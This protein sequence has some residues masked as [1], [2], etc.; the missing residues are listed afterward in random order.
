MS[1]AP[2]KP[3]DVAAPVTRRLG[4]VAGARPGPLLLVVAGI[5]GNE[6]AGV[7]ALQRVL[8][9]LA[10]LA[11]RMTG[12]VVALAGNLRALAANQRFLHDDL[13]RRW[14][15]DEADRVRSGTPGPAAAPEDHERAELL[16]ELDA[17]IACARGPVYFL[18]LHTTSAEGIPFAMVS[19][20]ARLAD[21]ALQFPLPVIVGML[22]Q[23]HGV[24]LE[25]MRERGCACLGVEGGQHGS[26]RSMAHHQAVAWIAAMAAGLVAGEQLPALP[27]ALKLLDE[28]RHGLPHVIEVEHRHA[29]APGDQFA[30]EPG[31]ANIQRI[32]AGQLLAR[33]QRGAIHADR[34][35]LLLLPLYQAKGD[36]GFFLGR[37][38]AL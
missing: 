5:H 33:D 1:S 14:T 16:R 19:R 25:Y 9:E 35:G 28:A 30:M 15:Q 11:P 22:E 3:A 34:D 32:R 10:A 27:A 31:F 7:R 21:F 36:D 2:V 29:I 37:E 38:L 23:V 20:Q 24:L 17:A 8:P 6:P 13:N 18:D 4:H 12:D 26:P